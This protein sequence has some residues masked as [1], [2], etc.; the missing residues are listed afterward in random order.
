MRH[1]STLLLL[2]T[3]TPGFTTAEPVIYYS[4][5]FP[6]SV[7]AYVS[8]EVRKDG[9]AVY[10][11]AADD[12]EPVSFHVAPD[13]VALI[14]SLADKLDHFRHPLESGLK[15]ANMGQKTFRYQDG[16]NKSEVQFNFSVDENAKLLLDWFERVTESQQLFFALERSV[17]F[18][19][20]GVNKSLLQ[21]E[22]AWDRKR[23]VAPERFLPLLDRVAKN[24]S[25]MHMARERAASLADLFRNP[26]PK[27]AAE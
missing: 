1:L 23:L 26:K 5:S 2:A 8:V 7:P 20:L 22:A 15:V 4:K 16:S 17:K 25:Y 21:V 24:D 18:D 13:D 19:R 27:S 6:G 3:C 10:K 12:E 14:F 11:E 9:S